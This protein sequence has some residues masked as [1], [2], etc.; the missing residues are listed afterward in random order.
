M[1]N[2]FRIYFDLPIHYVWVCVSY[3]VNTCV[4][5][6]IL[7]ARH[8]TIFIYIYIHTH[9]ATHPRDIIIIIII[10]I[11]NKL[12]WV[13]SRWITCGCGGLY[14]Y[15]KHVIEMC[16]RQKAN[17]ESDHDIDIGVELK[18][19]IYICTYM[20]RIRPSQGCCFGHATPQYHH[21]SRTRSL[22]TCVVLCCR[23]AYY[24]RRWA[25]GPSDR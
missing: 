19:G 18:T 22:A 5:V 3:V 15:I 6:W 17:R 12:C 23:W 20:M 7:H 25:V 10:I 14:V 21:Q 24:L 4:A 11:D 16:V 1:R 2:Y 9:H 13:W 8:L